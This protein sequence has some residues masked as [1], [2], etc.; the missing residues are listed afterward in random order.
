VI[1]IIKEIK[2]LDVGAAVLKGALKMMG[3]RV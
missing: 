1:K 2:V 3:K